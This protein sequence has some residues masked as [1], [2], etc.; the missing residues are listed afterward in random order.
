VP[1]YRNLRLAGRTVALLFVTQWLVFQLML[2]D[3]DR[4]EVAARF[5]LGNDFT[6]LYNA[7]GLF[8]S[9]TNPYVETSFIPLPTALYLPILLHHLSFWNALIVFRTI[10]FLLVVVAIFWLCRQLRLDAVDSALMLVISLTYGPFYS[11]LAGGN[12]DALMVALLIFACARNVPLRGALVGLSIGTK[13]YSLLLIP[14]LILR[15]RW[16]EVLWAIAVLIALLLPFIRY[17]PDALSSISH[18]TSVLRLNA[19]ESPAV[20]FILL[21][22]EKRVWLWRSCYA[23]LWGGTFLARL[24][25]DAKDATDLENERFRALDYLPWMAGAPLLVFTYTGIIL[26]PVIARLLQKNQHRKLFWAE[27]ATIL[28]FLLTGLYP[29]IAY[30]AFSMLPPLSSAPHQRLHTLVTAIAPLGISAMLIGSS[31]AAWKGSGTRDRRLVVDNVAVTRPCS[32]D[33]PSRC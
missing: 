6:Y 19:N 5:F 12:L 25:A 13:F 24:M 15:R 10:S 26:L 29:I 14:V 22:G 8:L 9:G 33:T 11:I 31:I 20:L 2:R 3:W 21:F 27:W 1:A 28:G 18:R 4:L 23:V 17:M 32:R 16:R 30:R 7:A